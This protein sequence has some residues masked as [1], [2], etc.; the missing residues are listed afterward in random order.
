MSAH[1]RAKL[2]VLLGLAGTAHLLQVVFGA[3]VDLST[4]A[5]PPVLLV[6]CFGADVAIM[7]NAK[8]LAA[9]FARVVDPQL[10]AHR[11]LG[12]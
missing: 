3:N 8:M 12:A 11:F 5:D 4:P 7:F 10:V 6:S 1:S 9:D 2:L